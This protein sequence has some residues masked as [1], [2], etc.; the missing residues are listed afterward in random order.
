MVMEYFTVQISKSIN[1]NEQMNEFEI[2]EN[3]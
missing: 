2:H 1:N 3:P